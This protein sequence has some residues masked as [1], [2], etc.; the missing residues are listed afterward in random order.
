[1]K[2]LDGGDNDQQHGG[3]VDDDQLL[4]MVMVTYNQ[5][6]PATTYPIPNQLAAID[7]ESA[8]AKT[9]IHH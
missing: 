9:E 6:Q 3:L 5:Q 8:M 1:M 2:W 7:Q 4:G